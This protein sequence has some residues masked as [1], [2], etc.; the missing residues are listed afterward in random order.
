MLGVITE[1]LSSVVLSP[2]RRVRDPA[3]HVLCV[4]VPVSVSV[5][6]GVGAPVSV[7][8]SV[9]VSGCVC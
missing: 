4:G 7:S 8:V 9:C 6:V 5:R 3:Q 1:P 2:H